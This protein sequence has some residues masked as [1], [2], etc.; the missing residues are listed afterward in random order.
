MDY[1][2]VGNHA[3]NVGLNDIYTKMVFRTGKTTTLLTK[4]HYFSANAELNRNANAYL[5]TEVD[6]VFTKQ[7]MK[8]V[9]LNIGY[10]QMFASGSM[11]LIKGNTTNENT[12]NWAWVMLTVKPTLFNSAK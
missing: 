8:S 11:R 12:N 3:N 6:L 7:L 10:S 1:F 2:Y 9:K 5:G 4:A